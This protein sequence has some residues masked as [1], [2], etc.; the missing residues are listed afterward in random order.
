MYTNLTRL[1]GWLEIKDF[2][3]NQRVDSKSASPALGKIVFFNKVYTQAGDDERNIVNRV[4]NDCLT[5]FKEAVFAKW[6]WNASH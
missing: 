4:G 2:Y 6:R 5:L 3:D 1:F